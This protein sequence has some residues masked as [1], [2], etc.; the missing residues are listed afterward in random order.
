MSIVKVETILRLIGE[1]AEEEFGVNYGIKSE[2]K[3]G[4]LIISG[5]NEGV[6]DGNIGGH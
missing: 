1:A 2:M 3:E 5:P 4:R 6:A